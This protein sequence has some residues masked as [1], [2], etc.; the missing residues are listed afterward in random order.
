M[1]IRPERPTDDDAIH[2]LTTVAFDPM[3]FSDGT[4]API[5][6]ALRR[7]GDLTLSLVAEE[8]GEVV[9]H[10]AFSPVTIDGADVGWYGLGPISVRPDRQRQGIGRALVADGLER[11]RALGATGCALIGNP[12]VYAPMGFSSDGRLTYRGLDPAI[13]QVVVF[14]GRR[15]AWRAPLR[16]R[17]RG[18][19]PS[20]GHLSHAAVRVVDSLHDRR[21]GGAMGRSEVAPRPRVRWTASRVTAVLVCVGLAF[22]VVVLQ[23]TGRAVATRADLDLLATMSPS[24]AAVYLEQHP[25]LRAEAMNA[26]PSTTVD[27]WQDLSDADRRRALRSSPE[28]V[29][30]LDGVEYATR[31]TANR[32][33]LDRLI[34]RAKR[35]LEARPG[36]ENATHRLAA[37]T[38]ILKAADAKHTPP[39]HLVT[40]FDESPRSR[41]SPSATST[42]RSR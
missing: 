28:M 11:L 10:V 32:R 2:D 5:I 29:G 27:W 1:Q 30:N 7:S 9:G 12:D 22:I 40:L 34:D 15:T 38:A 14:S 8:D 18:R 6:R 36:D 26:D 33:F 19:R 3:P 25:Q 17:L 16:P 20:F 39:R 37:L 13:V 4:E 41:R 23:P 35:S 31:D 42:R 21:P 24:E